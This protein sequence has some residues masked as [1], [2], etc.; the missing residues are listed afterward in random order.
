M[1]QQK[2]G[3]LDTTRKEISEYWD[4]VL[5][6]VDGLVGGGGRGADTLGSADITAVFFETTT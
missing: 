2:V 6:A 1:L 4:E 3:F 5:V